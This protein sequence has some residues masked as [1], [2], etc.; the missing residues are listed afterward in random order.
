MEQFRSRQLF[1]I[2]DMHARKRREIVS[3]MS[4]LSSSLTHFSAFIFI[5]PCGYSLSSRLQKLETKDENKTEDKL[6]KCAY[7][8]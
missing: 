8:S 2:K 7:L 4:Y 1:E 6:K 3:E 5:A